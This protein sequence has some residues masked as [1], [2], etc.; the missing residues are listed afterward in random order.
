MRQP[1]L[2]A[3]ALVI[4]A[5]TAVAQDAAYDWSGLYLGANGGWVSSDNCWDFTTPA[6]VVSG[7]EGCH[8]GTGA[9]IGGQIGYRWQFDSFVFGFE[10]QGNWADQAGR[11]VSLPFPAFVNESRLRAFGLFTGQIGYAWNT[12]LLYVK[13]GA[14]ITSN[15][16]QSFL[17]ATGA[18]AANSAND[19]RWTGVVGGGFEYGF[20][21]NWSLG[22]EYNHIFKS[23]SNLR[24]T[25]NGVAGA[26]GTLFGHNNISQDADFVSARLNFRWGGF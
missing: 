21:P 6:G 5:G 10:A 2:A 3:G 13:G 15:S 7:F 22:V 19:T 26:P 17:T 18:Q 9:T 11:N 4:W 16:Y 24:F 12:T 25:N 23:S 14:A 1:L 20:A 8:T